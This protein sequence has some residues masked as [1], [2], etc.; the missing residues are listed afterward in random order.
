MITDTNIY[1]AG[2]AISMAIKIRRLQELEV[3]F[4]VKIV[5]GIDGE[6]VVS[7]SWDHKRFEDAIEEEF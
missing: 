4:D 2:Q 6:S 5:K 1:S 3:P 7:V